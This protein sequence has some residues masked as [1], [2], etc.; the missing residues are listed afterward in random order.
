MPPIANQADISTAIQTIDD[1]VQQ[2]HL[3]LSSRENIAK[4]LQEPAYFPFQ[5]MLLQHIVEKRWSQLDEAFWT[6]IPFGTGGRRGRMYP[7]GTNAIND[8]TIGESAAGLAQYVRQTVGG[9]AGLSCAIAYDT[10][11]QSRHF[12]ELCA[13][14]MVATGFQVYFLDDYRSTPELSFLVRYKQCSCGIMVTASHN[15]PSDNAVKIYWSSGGQIL[16]PHDARIIEQVMQH[17]AEIDEG[18]T[19]ES[20][21]EQGRIEICTVPTDRA[22][23]AAVL[24]QRFDGPRDLRILYSPL[25]GVGTSAV[26]P[27]LTADG[28]ADVDVFADH[29]EPN[30][31]FPNVPNHVSNPENAA[32]FTSIIE[33]AKQSGAELVLASDPDCDRLG[34]AAPP[35]SDPSSEWQTM[36]GNQ[37]GALL[38]DYVLEQRRASLTEKNY[39]VKTLVT[40]EMVRRIGE[41]YGIQ[42]HGNLPVGFKWIG[43]GNG[44]RGPRRVPVG[45]RRIPW[46]LSWPVCAGQRRC[47]RRDVISRSGGVLESRR[48]NPA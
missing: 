28:F 40:T 7:I 39:L 32:V 26:V 47:G 12:A 4:W 13:R 43:G 3:Q 5:P 8:R 46:L 16:P 11:H 20:G 29:A 19:F 18:D 9:S 30:G 34:C 27:V 22:F 45:D 25:H 14:I 41:S 31:D 35:S 48:A 23:V 36:N 10:R 6:T 42:T 1:A 44:R 38:S 21:I 33:H 17:V 37:I 2:E 15:P 24:G